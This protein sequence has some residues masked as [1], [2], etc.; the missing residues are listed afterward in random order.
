MYKEKYYFEV[1]SPEYN[2]LKTPGSPERGKGWKHSEA[3]I[4]KMRIATKKS[5]ESP[6]LIAKLSLAQSSCFA[7]K[8]EV[9]DVETQTTT[10]YHAIRAAARALSIDKRYIEH[11]ILLN[12]DKPVLGKYTFKLVSCQGEAL[13]SINSA[14]KVQKACKKVEVTNVETKEVLIYPSV[15]SVAKALKKK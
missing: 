2:I 13:N 15:G 4:E 9:T 8:V 3:T 6:E 5:M 11:Y 10:T 14:L 12:Q 7:I 1:Y